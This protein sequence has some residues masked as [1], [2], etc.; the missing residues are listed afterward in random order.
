MVSA[1]SKQGTAEVVRAGGAWRVVGTDLAFGR[2]TLRLR[3]LHRSHHTS[4][5][6]CWRGQP[7]IH[8]M[9]LLIEHTSRVPCSGVGGISKLRPCD[10]GGGEVCV[11]ARCSCEPIAGHRW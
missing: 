9:H 5:V 3:R 11:Q 8:I 7:N 4:R 6:D 1:V 10:K 2:H